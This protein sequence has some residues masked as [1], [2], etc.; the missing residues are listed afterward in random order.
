VQRVI[1]NWLFLALTVCHRSAR[2]KFKASQIDC[3]TLAPKRYADQYAGSA[4]NLRCSRH[5]SR[6]FTRSNL[7]K[8]RVI[9]ALMRWS[10]AG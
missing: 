6:S 4:L 7:S 9:T 1:P 10:A 2:T 3:A 5:A 8:S